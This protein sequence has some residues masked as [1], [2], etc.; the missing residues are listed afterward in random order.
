MGPTSSTSEPIH[1]ARRQARQR[2]RREVPRAGAVDALV[3]EGAILSIDTTRASVASVALVM[4]AQI[5][6]DV[7]GGRLDAELPHV[8]ADHPESLYIV[9]HYGLADGWP[10]RPA[11][12]DADTSVYANGC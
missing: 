12:L 1:P 4:R 10:E 7:S 3:P 2:G 11:V 6:N 9:Q 8:V 5:I